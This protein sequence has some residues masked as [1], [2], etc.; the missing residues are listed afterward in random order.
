MMTQKNWYA[1]YTRPQNEKKVA[2]LLSKKKIENFYP[3][4]CTKTRSSRGSKLSY[5][6]LFKSYVF[7][8]VSATEAQNLRQINGV[9]NVLYWLGMPAIIAEHEIDAIKEFTQNHTGI[10][11]ERTQ[12]DVNGG[13]TR[14]IGD[15]SFSMEGNQVVVKNRVVK[16]NLSSLGY[17]MIA[18]LA[19]DN[20]MGRDALFMNRKS[21]VNS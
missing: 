7:V 21:L 18:E 16:V 2:A 3:V 1:L 5:E 19:E 14:I 13:T 6:P 10:K 8:H 4:T 11:L 12:I 20:I 9:V 17:T 15:N